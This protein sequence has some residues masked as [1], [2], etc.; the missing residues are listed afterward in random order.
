MKQ[1]WFSYVNTLIG[2]QNFLNVLLQRGG[3]KDLPLMTEDET[4][5]QRAIRVILELCI[6]L[7]KEYEY[8]ICPPDPA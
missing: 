1:E 3:I 8:D 5:D 7:A 6:E 2:L 4:G